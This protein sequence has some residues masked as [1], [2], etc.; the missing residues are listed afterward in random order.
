MWKCLSG[1]ILD[2]ISTKLP[3]V[4]DV[5]IKF[6][7]I[8][9]VTLTKLSLKWSMRLKLKSKIKLRDQKYNFQNKGIKTFYLKIEGPTLH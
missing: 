9:I 2:A 1:Q 6:V 8:S 7:N 5:D 4:Y 3:L